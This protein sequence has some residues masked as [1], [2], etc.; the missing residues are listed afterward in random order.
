M[1]KK[2]R[3]KILDGMQW[4][5][6]IILFVLAISGFSYLS[7]SYGFSLKDMASLSFYQNLANPSVRIIRIQEGLR[8][9]QVAEIVGEELNWNKKEKEEFLSAHIALGIADP[10]GYFFPKSYMI[11]KD[12]DPLS[13]GE[14]MIQ[15]FKDATG[16]I[17]KRKSSQ[18]IN[19]DTAVKIASIIQ[20]E[21][22]GKS[23]MKLISGIIWNRLFNGMRLQ[24]DATLQYAKGNEKDGWWQRVDSK[25]KF[26]DSPYNTYK[27]YSLPPSAISNPGL[28]ALEAAFNPQKTDCLYYLHD[29]NQKIH[30]SKTY[31]EHRKKIN[32][33]Y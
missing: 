23:D 15:E 32:L 20:R 25:D 28:A 11:H 5:T 14:K 2:K 33:Y 21:A 13:V 30:C 12:A 27:Y 10:E 24:I 7:L 1:K 26:I 16:S 4:K 22:G 17:Q 31:E 3:I 19:E 8:K 9:E 29:K 18:I 6:I